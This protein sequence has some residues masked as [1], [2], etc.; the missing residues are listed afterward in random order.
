MPETATP[1]S[2]ERIP[3]TP[4]II[5]AHAPY[6]LT[7]EMDRPAPPSVGSSGVPRDEPSGPD[8][9]LAEVM[10]RQGTLEERYRKAEEVTAALR[11]QWAKQVETSRELMATAILGTEPARRRLKAAAEEPA[12]PVPTPL[13]E[14]APEGRGKARPFLQ[15]SP[16]AKGAI[17]SVIQAFGLLEQIG[18]GLLARGGA[19]PALGALTG[20]MT[21]WAEGDQIRAERDWRTYLAQVDRIRS[22]NATAMRA[23]EAATE[24]HRSNLAAAQAEYTAE[25]GR[26]GLVDRMAAAARGDMQ[27]NL[28]LLQTEQGLLGQIEGSSDRLIQMLLT[29]RLR[30]ET[31]KL[32]ET[33]RTGMLSVAQA[34][35]AEKK[36]TND[37]LF[38][39]IGGIAKGPGGTS[40]TLDGLARRVAAGASLQEL[41]IPR[42]GQW[43]PFGIAVQRRAEE[44]MHEAGRGP[45]ALNLAKANKEANQTALKKLAGERAEYQSFL[46]SFEKAVKVA[47][48]L[49][50]KINRGP[51]PWVNRAQLWVRANILGD[52]DARDM[53]AQMETLAREADRVLSRA[54]GLGAEHSREKAREIYSV[55]MTPE[56]LESLIANVLEPDARNG[57][58]G[59]DEAMEALR[60]DIG[61]PLPT[62]QQG[63]T[64]RIRRKGG[65]PNAPTA[66]GSREMWEALPEEEREQYEVVK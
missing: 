42:F 37:L 58:A 48:E 35:A 26:V 57:L 17:Q 18:A 25:L 39:L 32:N 41:G 50:A 45:E 7:P 54:K 21:G 22:E 61:R 66:E 9:L 49:S 64:I 27:T 13:P 8:A 33:Y 12:P 15:S 28:S 52:S 62:V 4:G 19:V 44:L 24:K 11:D 38:S 23:W 47:R 29:D 6:A 36:R 56:N 31:Q 43:V 16:D 1:E 5:P 59:F 51:S 3:I 46:V 60:T 10:K 63:A 20:A 14:P 53:Y 40:E 65:D 55:G 2:R 34:N 30:Q